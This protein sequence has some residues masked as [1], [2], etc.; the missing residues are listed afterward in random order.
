M[1]K[2]QRKELQKALQMAQKL[3]D[4]ISNFL[5]EK[6]VAKPKE[7]K[8]KEIKPK[9]PEEMKGLRNNT[10]DFLN[11]IRETYG[12]NWVYPNTPEIKQLAKQ[13]NASSYVAGLAKSLSKRSMVQT[14]M[15]GKRMLRFKVLPK[16]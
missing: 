8:V 6:Q 7:V 15:H 3:C 2:N 13:Y 4:F 5:A 1:T 9:R 10:L 14:E 11:A 12:D 16:P